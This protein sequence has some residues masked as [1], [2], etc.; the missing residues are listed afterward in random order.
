M[1]EPANSPE[2]SFEQALSDLEAIVDALE[3][4]DMPLEESLAAFEQGVGL[5]RI[6]QQA[7]DNAEQRARILT[8]TRPEAEP[9]P[10]DP[11]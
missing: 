8:D 5:T 7:L 2:P 6:C 11:Q 10:F 9:E 1:K 3:K 4:G